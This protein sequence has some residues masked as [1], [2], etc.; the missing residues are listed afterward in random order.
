MTK[1]EIDLEKLV[2]EN[3]SFEEVLNF[4][5]TNLEPY[6]DTEK[7]SDKYVYWQIL[8]ALNAKVNGQ[9]RTKVL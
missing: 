8:N 7:L 1:R 4:C 6:M 2:V 9:K 5:V 3:Y